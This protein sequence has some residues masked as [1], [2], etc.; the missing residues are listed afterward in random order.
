MCPSFALYRV[1]ERRERVSRSVKLFLVTVSTISLLLSPVA[2]LSNYAL[3][4]LGGMFIVFVVWAFFGFSY[5]SD[6]LS[7]SL[8][9][10]SKVLSFTTAIMLFL[11]PNKN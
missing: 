10:V 1:K 5:P 3:F 2:S 11:K 6:P 9:G 7:F 8:N 4:S